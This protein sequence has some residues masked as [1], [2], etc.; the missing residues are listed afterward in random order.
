MRHEGFSFYGPR[1][2]DKGADTDLKH[3]YVFCWLNVTLLLHL[4]WCPSVYT[5]FCQM[6]WS[7]LL[8]FLYM[9]DLVVS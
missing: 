5:S 8:V 9:C 1:M 6:C 3:V 7:S 4:I 2:S